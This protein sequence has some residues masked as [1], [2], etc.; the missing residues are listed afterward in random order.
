MKKP[1]LCFNRT[2]KGV[3][4]QNIILCRLVYERKHY[5]NI[6]ANGM[7]RCS[8]PSSASYGVVG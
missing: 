2:T 5:G 4:N 6:Y 8:D 1:S 7:G 3:L